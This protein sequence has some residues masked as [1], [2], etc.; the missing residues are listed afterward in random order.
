[1]SMT[2]QVRFGALEIVRSC[3]LT[4]PLFCR[5]TR[6]GRAEQGLRGHEIK[7]VKALRVARMKRRNQGASV[8]VTAILLPKPRERLLRL[9][10]LKKAS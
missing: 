10:V 4:A 1:M 5:L 2:T 7:A 3:E 9:N 8:G 6:F